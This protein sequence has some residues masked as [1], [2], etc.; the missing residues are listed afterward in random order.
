MSHITYSPA[1]KINFMCNNLT[2]PLCNARIKIE[3]V[4]FVKETAEKDDAIW[5][6]CTVCS[7]SA[8]L[9]ANELSGFNTRGSLK[10]QAWPRPKWATPGV[11]SRC[12]AGQEDVSWTSDIQTLSEL[13]KQP[14]IC[15]W[16]LTQVWHD[17]LKHNL[18]Q[19]LLQQKISK[20]AIRLTRFPPRARVDFF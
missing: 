20:R 11:T 7:A 1:I 10:P 17:S 5:N 15:D 19:K 3:G 13:F 8:M 6:V 14:I 12:C 2:L 4:Q 18:R 16:C 9:M